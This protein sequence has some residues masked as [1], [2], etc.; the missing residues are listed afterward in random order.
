MNRFF[1]TL[2]APHKM[3]YVILDENLCIREIS[4]EVAQFADRPDEVA[5][6][7]DIRLGF[8]EFIGFEADLTAILKGQQTLWELRGLNRSSNLGSLLYIDMYV[9]AYEAEGG[10]IN[11]LIVLI[12]DITQRMNLEQELRQSANEINLLLGA[13][14]ASK[15]YIEKIIASIADALFIT[16]PGGA[17]KTINRAAQDLFGYTK[18]EL[19]GK[20]ITLIITD[21]EFI[22]QINRQEILRQDRSVYDIEVICKTRDGAELPI[23]F[24]CSVV[25]TGEEDTQGIIYVGRDI[26]RRKQVE[27]ELRRA[28]DVAEAAN[29]AK[30][31]FLA[32]MSHEIRT[33]LNGVIGMTGLLLETKLTPQQREFVETIRISG[34]AL[35]TLIND[36][37]DFSKIEAGK[38]ELEEHPFELITCVEETLDLLASKAAEKNIELLHLID[39]QVPPFI[40]GDITRLRQ[41]LANL[42]DNAIKFTEKGEVMVTVEIQDQGSPPSLDFDLQFAKLTRPSVQLR[43]TVRDTGIGIPAHKMKLLFQPFSQVDTSTTRKY[44]GTGLGLAICARLVAL[45]GGKIWV[46]S[47]EGEGTTFFFTV[48]VRLAAISTKAPERLLRPPSL[49]NKRVLIVDDNRTNLHIL[50]LQCQSWGM[51]PRAT[52][53]SQEALNWIKQGDPF[54]VAIL[55]GQMPDLDGLTLGHEI[56]KLRS[57]ESLPMVLLSSASKLEIGTKIPKQVFSKHV[58]KPVKQSQLFDILIHLLAGAKHS[59][60]SYK[61]KGKLNKRLAERLPLRILVAEDHVINQK[62]I[63]RMLERM[64]YRADI[65]GNGLE[66]LAALERQRYDLIFMDVHMPEMDGLEATRQIVQKF[67]TRPRIIA[68]TANAMWGDREKCLNAGMD[69]YISK[70]ILV[71]EV[72]KAVER[73]GQISVDPAE[74]VHEEV[75]SDG[76]IDPD[77]IA[78]FTDVRKGG[79]PEFLYEM[80]EIFLDQSPGLIE[81]IRQFAQAGD[82]LGMGQAAHKL[83]GGSLNFGARSLSKIC[84]QIERKS[85]DKDLSEIDR[86]IEE[87]EKGYKQISLELEKI[88]HDIPLGKKKTRLFSKTSKKRK[89]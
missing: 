50:T 79:S 59:K 13:L 40:V 21:E 83:R 36:I 17:I 63:L 27:I 20:P 38:L 76:V 6:G 75:Q 5:L 3:E 88:K 32:N 74:L 42:L 10:V 58:L 23:S 26:S 56:R 66:V 25:R 22:N 15:S 39:S 24:S 35:L 1:K 57:K 33:P 28:K 2:L 80:I 85:L 69:D 71:E 68:M 51:L 65:A 72:Q 49:H 77:R 62:L 37:L 45:M 67:P 30:N 43:F 8:P 48:T 70:P 55:D 34:D 73:W 18:S 89:N 81:D 53:S 64:G 87:L 14:T 47:T 60:K 82:A 7:K 11:S 61:P 52:T 78:E 44:G 31:E 16:T 29:R 19:I 86:L 9:A 4:N 41:V 54:E 84:E 46:E 12:E